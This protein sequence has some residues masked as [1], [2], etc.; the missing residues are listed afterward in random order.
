MPKWRKNGEV[1]G[2]LEIKAL[3]LINSQKR[4]CTTTYQKRSCAFNINLL[5]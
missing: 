2:E 1:D 3:Q 5:L 4:K